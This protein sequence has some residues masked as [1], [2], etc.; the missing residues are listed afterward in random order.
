[1]GDVTIEGCHSSLNG[2]NPG[3][4]PSGVPVGPNLMMN[5]G[6]ALPILHDPVEYF[7]KF[8]SLKLRRKFPERSSDK[9]LF[10][11]TIQGER[12]T[13]YVEN[14]KLCVQQEERLGHVLED[15]TR[16]IERLRLGAWK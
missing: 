13:I 16:D 14:S 10:S 5:I 4:Q 1:M 3:L 11:A 8:R 2:Y 6:P 12:C 9:H 7:S 15:V